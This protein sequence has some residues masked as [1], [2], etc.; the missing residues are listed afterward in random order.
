M[1]AALEDGRLCRPRPV[2]DAWRAQ[3]VEALRRAFPGV[4]F[5]APHEKALPTTLNFSIPGL[6]SKLLLDLFD[7]ASIR[8]SGGSACGASKALPSYVL[9]ALS[10]KFSAVIGG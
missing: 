8:V 2:L 9:E 3:I 10:L 1:L 6:S 4:V 7:A 5:N